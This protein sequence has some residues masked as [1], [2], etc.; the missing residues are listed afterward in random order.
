MTRN[1]VLL[2]FTASPFAVP[3][4]QFIGWHFYDGLL[5]YCDTVFAYNSSRAILFASFRQFFLM[6]NR[7][8]YAL[9]FARTSVSKCD[10]DHE[11][12]LLLFL[13]LPEPCRSL[14][15]CVSVSVHVFLFIIDLSQPPLSLSFALALILCSQHL[16]LLHFPFNINRI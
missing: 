7:K 16:R 11:M 15:A 9:A 13:M 5:L 14:S 4:H 1:T 6:K 10:E 2:W 12:H 8:M 3:L